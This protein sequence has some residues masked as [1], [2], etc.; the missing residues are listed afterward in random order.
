EAGGLSGQFEFVQSAGADFEIEPE[1]YDAAMCIGATWAWGGL[2]GTLSALSPGVRAG[3]HVV[4]GEVYRT[5]G[6]SETGAVPL[7]SVIDSFE[8]AGLAVVCLIRS[9]TDDFDT[10]H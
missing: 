2:G 10:Y 9:T 4:A 6:S 7:T 3:G 1:R 8:E 5:P